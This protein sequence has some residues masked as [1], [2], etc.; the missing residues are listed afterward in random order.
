MARKSADSTKHPKQPSRAGAHGPSEGQPTSR[1]AAKGMQSTGRAAP[2]PADPPEG[3]AAAFPSGL[4]LRQQRFVAEYLT[5]FN[6]TQAAI[7]SGYSAHT[8]SSQGERL[9]R[10]VE[11]AAAI[12]QAAKKTATK[13][14]LT[15]DRVLQETARIA[16]FDARKLFRDDG[17][18]KSLHELDD[19]T[20][21][22]ISG[23][24][25]LEEFENREGERTQVGVIKKYRIADKNNALERAAKLLALFGDHNKQLTDPLANLLQGLKPLAMPVT[26]K[27]GDD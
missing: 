4:N 21:A 16:F 15:R 18:P 24:D 23:L 27:P 26:D 17:S 3:Q 9:L 19:D 6:A 25:V 20:A 7:R 13:L 8:A 12:G 2:L 22:A 10:N 5:D 11:V 14:E 1:R